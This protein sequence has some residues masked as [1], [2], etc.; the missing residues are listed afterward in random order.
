VSSFIWGSLIHLDLSFVQGDKNLSICIILHAD[1]QLKEHH[2][3][4]MLFSPHWMVLAPLS[5]FI[6]ELSPLIL[7]DIKEKSV[8]LPVI[9]VVRGRI[10]FMWLSSFRFA[11]RLLSCFSLSVVPLLVL[12]FFLYYPLKGWICGKML[13]KFSFIIEYLALSIYG[14]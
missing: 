14:N 9:F 7:R 6:G 5:N 8:L 3:L 12:E 4:K 10:L 13:C 2:L 11:E 1:H